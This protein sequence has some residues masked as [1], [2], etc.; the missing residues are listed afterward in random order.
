MS[1]FEPDQD[2]HVP[3]PAAAAAAAEAVP[4]SHEVSRVRHLVASALVTAFMAAAGWIALPIGPVPITLQVFGVL[5][6]AL[7]LSW[8]W[9]A[10]ALG[11]Y[12]VMGVAGIPVFAH[13]TAGVGVVLGPTGGYLIGFVLAAGAGAWLR[14]ALERRGARQAVADVVAVV[15]VIAI[16]YTVG[17]LQLALVTAMGLAKAFVVGVLPFLVLDAI[18]AAVAVTIAMAVRKS[19]VRL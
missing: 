8:E 10:A 3:P 11:L 14:R 13:G 2:A 17:W 7:L 15:L 18:K 16:I 1:T 12:F 5:L 19:G 6:A 9:A 4:A